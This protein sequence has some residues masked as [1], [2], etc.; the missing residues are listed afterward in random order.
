MDTEPEDDVA[1]KRAAE[2][3]MRGEVRQIMA[4]HGFRA[5]GT[6]PLWFRLLALPS[7]WIGFVV[8]VI[9]TWLL[10]L[11]WQGWV[12]SW[13]LF[14]CFAQLKLL[15]SYRLASLGIADPCGFGGSQTLQFV[16]MRSALFNGVAAVAMYVW[17]SR[18]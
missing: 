17:A 2:E 14:G 8:F 12:G 5:E 4:A 13:L 7:S 3:Q 6:I 18:G 10:H 9:I 16:A 11:H 15:A 1:N